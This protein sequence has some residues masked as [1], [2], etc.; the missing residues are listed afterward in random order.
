MSVTILDLGSQ[1]VELKIP[2]GKLVQPPGGHVPTALGDLRLAVAASLEAPIEFPEL[3][4][5]L[6]PDDHLAI[7]LHEDIHGL[8]VVLQAVLEH[9]LSAGIQ[10]SQ[11]A[12][13]VPPRTLG[14][15]VDWLE[16]LP[17]ELRGFQLEEHVPATSKLA[18]LAN[19]KDGR[20]IYLNRLIVDAD[21]VIIIG[22][23]RFDPIHG[24]ASGLADVF[25]TF[26]DEPTVQE[27]TRHLHHAL[28]LQHHPFAIWKETEEVGWHL[29]MPFVVCLL[30]GVGNTV[31]RVLSGT[32]GPVRE[33]AETWLRST[34]L[35]RLPYQ[36]DLVVGTLSGTPSQQTFAQVCEAAYRASRMVHQGG[37]VAIL[38]E[39]GAVLPAGSEIVSQG[40]TAVEGL[41]LLRKHPQFDSRPWWY[42]ANGLLQAKLFLS[43]RMQ[44]EVVESLFL[45]PFDQHNQVQNLIDQAKSVLIVEGVD[46][47]HFELAKLQH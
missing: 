24:V 4:R 42:L 11:V 29:G 30:E 40:E 44:Q 22:K 17:E 18:Y 19:T 8:A 12:V 15:Q 6:T 46:Q 32:A 20:R 7:V 21:Q 37:K 27:L 25:P 34:H 9:V 39:A 10:I 1:K 36:V 43:C 33:Q 16:Q 26:S 3:R 38:S 45:V 13:V 41:A 35:L 2:P 28:P 47:L 5:A 23:V 14:M 31:N